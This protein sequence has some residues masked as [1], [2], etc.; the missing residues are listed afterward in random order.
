[1]SVRGTTTPLSPDFLL[2]VELEVFIR[3]EDAV[4]FIEEVRGDDPEIAAKLRIE[5]RELEAGV[6]TK[7]DLS[8][9][10]MIGP[11]L[12]PRASARR[13]RAAPERDSQAAARH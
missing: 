2:G 4:R 1:L 9:D 5:E 13:R 7:D 8:G 6:R 12:T 10:R 11:P 3:R